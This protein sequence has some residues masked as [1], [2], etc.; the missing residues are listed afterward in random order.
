MKKEY[1][2]QNNNS[3]KPMESGRKVQT[4]K[5]EEPEEIEEI[6]RELQKVREEKGIVVEVKFKAKGKQIIRNKVKEMKDLVKGQAQMRGHKK[7]EKAKVLE[8]YETNLK[9][10]EEHYEKSVKGITEQKH[11]WQDQEVEITIEEYHLKQKRKEIKKSPQCVELLKQ[12]KILEKQIK[13]AIA[14]DDLEL[15]AQ[16]SS[17]LKDLKS[18]NPLTQQEQ[19][20]KGLQNKRHEIKQLIKECNQRLADCEKERNYSLIDA[21]EDRNEKLSRLKKQNIFQRIVQAMTKGKGREAQYRDSTIN[22]MTRKV[23]YINKEVKQRTENQTIDFAERMNKK[24]EK[25]LG[26]NQYGTKELMNRTQ[27]RVIGNIDSDKNIR[28]IEEQ[29]DIAI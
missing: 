22:R 10:I 9:K 26:K 4:L 23:E 20:I 15:V 13:Q 29:E 1:K 7:E 17:E 25:I 3:F 11:N 6:I 14:K 24:R 8:R 16:K 19:K 2:F 21:L 27:A 18:R 5:A 12:E 28:G